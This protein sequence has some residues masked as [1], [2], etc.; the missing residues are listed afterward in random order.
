MEDLEK[1][2]LGCLI[3]KYKL[4]LKLCLECKL[5]HAVKLAPF[6]GSEAYDSLL[7]DGKQNH[8]TQEL[9]RWMGVEAG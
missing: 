2:I 9:Y 8:V 3:A 1:Q 5:S 4:T 6:I 7:Q